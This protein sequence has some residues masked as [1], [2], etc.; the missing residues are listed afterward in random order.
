MLSQ[1]NAELQLV[2]KC[3]V[4]VD[5]VVVFNVRQ[6]VCLRPF[7]VSFVVVVGNESQFDRRLVVFHLGCQVLRR[8]VLSCLP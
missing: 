2:G 7:D 6:V 8:G 3:V 1:P 5:V 4:E